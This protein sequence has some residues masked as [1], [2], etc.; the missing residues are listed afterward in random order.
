M[1][2]AYGK[3]EATVKSEINNQGGSDG[4]VRATDF[5]NPSIEQEGDFVVILPEDTFVH[6]NGQE[7]MLISA[8]L[9]SGEPL[10]LWI[11]FDDSSFSFRG[12][13]PAGDPADVNIRLI[14]I[15]AS[16]NQAITGFTIRFGSAA[17]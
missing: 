15:D 16:G 13:A 6:S 7:S 10:P 2:S 4:F 1:L 12:T 3:T 17:Q 5:S 11:T 8:Q 9:E 14:A